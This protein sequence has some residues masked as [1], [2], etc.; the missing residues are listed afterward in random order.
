[1]KL[2]MPFWNLD[3]LPRYMPQFTALATHTGQLTILYIH[4]EPIPH[5]DIKYRKIEPPRALNRQHGMLRL[6]GSVHEQVESIPFDIVYSLSGRW[7]Q[8]AA[9]TIS[10][11][12]DTPLVIR[13]RGD[14]RR[15]ARIQNRKL[16]R[17][18]F[19]KD[20]IRDSFKQASLV[21]PIAQKLVKVAQGLGAKNITN[22]IPNGVDHTKFKPTPQPDT[23]VVGYVGRVSIE[24]GSRFL[25]NLVHSTP[26]THYLIAGETQDHFNPPINC[27]LLGPVPYTQIQEVYQA[28][29]IIVIPSLI[30]A[31]PNAE[32]EAYASARPIIITPDAHPEEAQ[33]HGWKYP[34][35][36]ESW[37]HTIRH[38]RRKRLETI[39]KEAH[40]YSKQFTWEIHG[41]RMAAAISTALTGETPQEIEIEQEVKH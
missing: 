13:L 21:I 20:Q 15:V 23:P 7:L 9:A 2:L 4:G 11:K 37:A 17:S 10:K 26:K 8:Q 35:N 32:L 24:K 38:L 29:S 28:S 34:H 41:I 1:M 22:P 39:G 5:P 40:E 3:I 16:L 14:E 31:Y 36:I 30:E 33:L 27:D 12:T 19:F 18:I 6:M 25:N